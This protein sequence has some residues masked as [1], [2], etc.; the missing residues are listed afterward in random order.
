MIMKKLLT[1]ILILSS[2]NSFSFSQ[3]FEFKNL[4]DKTLKVN[5]KLMA[6]RFCHNLSNNKFTMYSYFGGNRNR[7]FY[8]SCAIVEYELTCLGKI[9]NTEMVYGNKFCIKPIKFKARQVQLL[10][11][12]FTDKYACKKIFDNIV[13]E[14]KSSVFKC[15]FDRGSERIDEIVD[16]ENDK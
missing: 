7:A 10:H 12:T 16:F 5:L 1:M 9:E 3:E 8:N 15:S 11:K 14:K 13:Q 2:T 4:K 6:G